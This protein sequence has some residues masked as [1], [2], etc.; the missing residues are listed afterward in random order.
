M[1]I[2]TTVAEVRALVDAWHK[3]GK[4]VGLVP[5]MGFLHEGHES[6]I[7]KAVAENDCVVVSDFVNPTQFGPQED[8]EAYP[9]DF[10]QDKAR[11]EKIGAAAIFHPAPEEMYHDPATYVNIERL[12]STLCGQSRPIH[13]RGV[14]TVVSK[15]FN[16][17]RPERAYFGEK[18]AQQLAIIRKMVTDLNFPVTIVGCPIVREADGLAKSSRNTYLSE[19]ER[20]AALC[21]SQAVK[22]GQQTIAPKMAAADVLARFWKTNRSPV[23]IIWKWWTRKPC[24]PQIAL[25]GLFWSRWPCISAKRVS[26][27]ISRSIRQVRDENYREDHRRAH[28]LYR[29]HHH[30]FHGVGIFTAG[31]IRLGGAVYRLVFRRGDVRHG[32]FHSR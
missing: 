10:E 1:Q 31:I 22:K 8:L 19:A 21:L 3:E 7:Q 13:F 5:T 25:T 32:A 12:S 4:T 23:W 9:R 26:L 16:I 6:L 14:C 27:I 28:A 2:C 30:H 20:R 18:D 17:V 24:S 11:C 29:R 15:L